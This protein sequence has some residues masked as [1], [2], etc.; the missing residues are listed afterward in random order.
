MRASLTDYVFQRLSHLDSAIDLAGSATTL[1]SADIERI[2]FGVREL[3]EIWA[4]L[5]SGAISLFLIE[6]AVGVAMVTALGVSI[7]KTSDHHL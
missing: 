2:Q 6:R 4:N 7:G 5:I 3:H 1:V